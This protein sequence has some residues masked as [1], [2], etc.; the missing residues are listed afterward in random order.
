MVEPSSARQFTLTLSISR[1]DYERLYR[2]QVSTVVARDRH[3]QTLQFPALSLRP[4][5]S[6]SGVQ[7]TFIISVDGNNRLLDIRRA[8]G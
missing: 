6:H 2:G 4:F 3:G 5:L 8:G 7:G 1:A